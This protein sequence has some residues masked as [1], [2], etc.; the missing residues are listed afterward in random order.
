MESL[1]NTLPFGDLTTS[2][3]VPQHLARAA[4]ALVIAFR[5]HCCWRREETR[6]QRFSGRHSHICCDLQSLGLE[7]PVGELGQVFQACQ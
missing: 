2:P 7:Q 5:L 3:N 6:G 4:E 1:D